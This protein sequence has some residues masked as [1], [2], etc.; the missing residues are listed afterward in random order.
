MIQRPT[1]ISLIVGEQVIVERILGTSPSSIVT[2]G[3]IFGNS[4]R[5]LNVWS[6][7]RYSRMASEQGQSDLL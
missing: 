3:C 2:D 7:T 4:L 1:A 5:R 6:S